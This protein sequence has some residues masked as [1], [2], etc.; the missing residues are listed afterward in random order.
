MVAKTSLG[1][2]PDGGFIVAFLGIH[3]V[4][5]A[6]VIGIV[7]PPP[8]VEHIADLTPVSQPPF[9]HSSF[10]HYQIQKKDPTHIDVR[11]GLGDNLNRAELN[12]LLLTE[13]N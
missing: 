1:I 3:I 8:L 10:I 12:V 7:P 2:K 4:C 5:A 9:I 6:L 11:L 13:V